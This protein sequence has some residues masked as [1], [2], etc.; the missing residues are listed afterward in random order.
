MAIPYIPTSFFVQQAN[1]QVYLSCDLMA[2]ANFYIFQLSSDGVNFSP[3]QTQSPFLLL[4]SPDVEV[5]NQ[6]WYKVAAS[7]A[8]SFGTIA[9]ANTSPYTAT[10]TTVPTPTGEM[11]L[12]QIRL[13]AQ[14][15][16][17]RVNSQF[18][19]TPEWN[20]YIN[21]SLF[22]LYDLLIDSEPDR[23]ITTPAQFN[24]NGSTFLYPLPDGAISFTD[25]SGS[26]YTARPFYKLMGVDLAVTSAN[27]AWV[28]IDRFQFI[29][30]NAYVYP[31]SNSTIYG[32]FNL[33]YRIVG[34]N[35]EFI[36]TPT[37]NQPI[38]LWYIPRI[39]QLLKDMDLTDCSVSGWIE[40]VIVD[41]AIKALQKEESDVSVLMA[42]KQ[43]LIARIENSAVNMDVGRPDKISD[44][45]RNSWGG[46]G[47]GSGYNGPIGGF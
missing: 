40:Y 1:R 44:V 47:S 6:Y 34:S 36:P 26:P 8:T 24:S 39:S 7:S 15:R 13:N 30:R 27:N 41:A 2:G 35:I 17:D 19:T 10:Q 32:V 45:R 21:Q 5:G 12:G 16:A 4:G 25:L 20:Q 33:Q 29:N 11:S 43:A 46:W 31:N 42:Q 28:T 14:E 37:A 38:R 9:D 3:M 18:V 22:E 23:F